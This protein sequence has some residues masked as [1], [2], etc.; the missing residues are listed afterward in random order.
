[1]Q[2]GWP[3]SSVLL[4]REAPSHED[5]GH[6]QVPNQH[7]VG[8]RLYQHCH[9]G[10]TDREQTLDTFGA[11][12]PFVLLHWPPA[13]P[14]FYFPEK[15]EQSASEK[16]TGTEKA[17]FARLSHCFTRDPRARVSKYPS[18]GVDCQR[19]RCAWVYIADC[20][21]VGVPGKAS[22]F[23]FYTPAGLFGMRR[24]GVTIS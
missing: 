8:R 4:F 19:Q 6:M 18:A 1:M 12:S 16:P 3:R 5:G 22:M 23:F 15:R 21:R 2:T 17:F 10:R 13:T 9:V 14:P 20:F 24:L 11:V 7:R